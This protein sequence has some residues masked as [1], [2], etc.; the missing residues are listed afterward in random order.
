[1]ERD[2]VALGVGDD[3][4]VPG[5]ADV[6][7]R[8]HH[9]PARLRRARERAVDVF[10]RVEVDERP[11]GRRLA[12]RVVDQRPARGVFVAEDKTSAKDVNPPRYVYYF[13]RVA[14]SGDRVDLYDFTKDD[15]RLLPTD[16]QKRLKAGAGVTVADDSDTAAILG[17]IDQRLATR[18]TLNTTTFRLVRKLN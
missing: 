18:P 6:R 4:D 8:Q 13:V 10:V 2:V 16:L 14:P 9:A 1:M 11:L 5:L 3:R 17:E 15:W 12:P 7:L